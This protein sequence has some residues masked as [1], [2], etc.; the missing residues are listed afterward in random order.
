[1]KKLIL[2]P[3]LMVMMASCTFYEI[4]PQY[5]HREKFLGYYDVR[6]YSET[7]GDYTYYE[8]KISRSRYDREVYLDNF[9]ASGIRVYAKVSFDDIRIPY[10]VV[11]GY[12]IDGSGW[13]RSGELKLTYRVR[14]IYNNSIADYCETVAW[15]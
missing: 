10:Q 7:Y 12:E 4:E 8:M 14:D 1:M 9:Y 5:D 6:E 3:V 13:F 2:I 15:R 11:N